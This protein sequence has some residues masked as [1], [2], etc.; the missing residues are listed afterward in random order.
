MIQCIG[1]RSRD[2]GRRVGSVWTAGVAMALWSGLAVLP[3]AEAA[4]ARTR[5]ALRAFVQAKD[6]SFSWKIAEARPEGEWGV[7]RVELQ[8]QTWRGHPWRHD[9]LM[10]RPA[11]VRNPDIA[12]LLIGGDGDVRSRRALLELLAKRAGAVAAAINRVPNQPLYDGRTEDT[13]IAYTFEQYVRTGDS[14]W[15]LLFPMVKSAVRGMD[16]VEDWAAREHGQKV[17]RF[18]VSGASKRG[19][20]TWLSAAAD[21]RVKAI[22]PMVIDMLNMKAQ[23][24]WAEQMYGRQSEQ[25]S[26]YTDYDFTRRMDEP[27]MVELRSWVDPYSYRKRY[28]LPKLLLLGTNDPYWVV[29]SLRHY[30]SELPEPKLVYQ[31]PNAGHDLAGGRDAHQTL[32]AFYQ[33]VADRQKLPRMKWEFEANAR[34]AEIEISVRPAAKAI[35]VWTANSN[36]RDFRDEQW[37]ATTLEAGRARK[38]G[39]TVDAPAGGFRAYMIEAEMVSATGDTYRLSTEARVVPDAPPPGAKREG[40]QGR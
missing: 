18:V 5:D 35:R 23:T 16:V 30:W 20:T 37:S 28:T 15:P 19:W 9:L 4:P 11:A 21:E 31:T 25:I 29:D 32:A 27:R 8:S 6:A 17:R 22:A 7:T 38:A 10:V 40:L 12:F 2:Q 26:D 34:G 1:T 14:S 39:H 33:M 36:D 13:L 3:G 24:A